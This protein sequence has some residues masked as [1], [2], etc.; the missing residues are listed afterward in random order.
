MQDYHGTPLDEGEIA[1]LEVLSAHLGCPLPHLSKEAL[2]HYADWL[3]ENISY[4]PGVWIESGHVTHLVTRARMF[5]SQPCHPIPPAVAS[6]NALTE[7]NG[8]ELPERFHTLPPGE[9]YAVLEIVHILDF[10]ESGSEADFTIEHGH[11]VA[12]RC[13]EIYLYEVPASIAEFIKLKALFLEQVFHLPIEIGNLEHLESLILHG[14]NLHAIPTTIGNLS[15]LKHLDITCINNDGYQFPDSL[16]R[17]Q[18]LE[19]LILPINNLAEVPS[20]ISHLKKLKKFIIL[21]NPIKKLPDFLENLQNLEELDISST[22]ITEVPP[23]LARLPNLRKLRIPKPDSWEASAAVLLSLHT[24]KRIEFEPNI[25]KER[26]PAFLL[27][28]PPDCEFQ[29]GFAPPADFPGVCGSILAKLAKGEPIGWLERHHPRLG[30]WASR[31]EGEC[32]RL[33]QD[34]AAT[35]AV[36]DNAKMVLGHLKGL[37]QLPA[38]SKWHYPTLL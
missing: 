37:N 7:F 32:I 13:S 22:D 16:K 35:P 36:K 10:H 15:Q 11:V 21:T 34:P 6:F 12:F 25:Q 31:I 20:W 19:T 8:Y 24:L 4:T 27:D 5:E 38:K 26:L 18:S 30:Q 33:L 3:E 23:V 17:L 2:P 14:S 9:R 28:M 1:A 29:N